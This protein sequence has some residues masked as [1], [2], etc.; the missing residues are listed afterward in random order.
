MHNLE[1]SLCGTC[2]HQI[3]CSLTHN[4]QSIWSC[5]EYEIYDYRDETFQKKIMKLSDDF[6]DSISNL[7][8]K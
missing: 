3:N 8:L 7:A 4:K 6:Y 1:S 5:S 2:E